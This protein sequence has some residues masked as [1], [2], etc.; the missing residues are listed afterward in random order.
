[1]TGVATAQG[2]D[3]Q[4]YDEPSLEE[5]T[6]SARNSL[7]S[8]ASLIALENGDGQHSSSAFRRHHD[9]DGELSYMNVPW[10]AKN[11]AF[12]Q[13]LHAWVC[14]P[15]PPRRFSIHP[16]LADVQ[17]APQRWLAKNLPFLSSD[18]Q[19]VSVIFVVWFICFTTILGASW[20]K[21]LRPIDGK[22]PLRL[23]CGTTLW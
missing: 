4:Q 16:W 11:F 10:L 7:D 3:I 23:T 5:E 21:G 18:T 1:M 15:V 20:R 22:A 9:R 17:L 19:V 13:R 12:T 8:A 6:V 14:G 2:A